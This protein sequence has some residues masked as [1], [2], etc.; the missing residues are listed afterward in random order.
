MERFTV[1]VPCTGG[2]ASHT[3]TIV[4]EHSTGS[5]GASAPGRVR[6]QFTCPLTG[7]AFIANF[8]PPV[9]AGR[10]FTVATVE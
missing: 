5:Y 6:L 10:P 3:H 1:Q 9:G 4:V 7:E 8:Q 2:G